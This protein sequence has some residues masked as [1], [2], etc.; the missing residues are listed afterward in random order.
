MQEDKIIQLKL[1]Q[2]VE[3]E[4]LAWSFVGNFSDPIEP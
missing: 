1:L 3:Q 2:K 4:F